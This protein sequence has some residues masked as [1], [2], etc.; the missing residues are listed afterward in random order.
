MYPSPGLEWNEVCMV[1]SGL[2][3]IVVGYLFSILEIVVECIMYS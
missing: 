3:D 2:G 1:I